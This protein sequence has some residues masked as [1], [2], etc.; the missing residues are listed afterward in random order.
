MTATSS[1]NPAG[2]AGSGT[3]E[4]VFVRYWAQHGLASEPIPFDGRSD[5][6][7]FI[8]RGIPA[9]GVFAGAEAPK[10]AEQVALT[11]ASRRAARPLLPRGLRQLRHG[12]WPAAGGDD[13]RLRG[14]PDAGEPGDRA[15]AGQS[16]QRQRTAS[17]QQFKG[18]LVHT[19]WYFARVKDALPP[20]TATAVVQE[21]DAYL[22]FKY[23]GHREARTR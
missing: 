7:G 13:E 10:T 15:A 1:G 12:H 5:Y 20:R 6:V 2:P 22:P 19:I 18:T 11:A 3:I 14:R 21:G 17:L 8:N 16:A 23:Q 4:D 9:G